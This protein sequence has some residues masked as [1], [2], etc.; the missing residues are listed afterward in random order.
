M[1][2]GCDGPSVDRIPPSVIRFCRSLYV[3]SSSFCMVHSK[4]HW[5][6]L[7]HSLSLVS[8]ESLR[9]LQLPPPV[10]K[11][12][13]SHVPVPAL[14][15]F[16]NQSTCSTLGASSFL[17]QQNFDEITTDCL[18]LCTPRVEKLTPGAEAQSPN[19]TVPSVAPDTS[20]HL[21]QLAFLHRIRPTHVRYRVVS[22]RRRC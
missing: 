16:G 17:G 13:L 8:T 3:F 11:D 18:A 21:E 6:Q 10:F 2:Y 5:I 20:R 15:R 1:C 7:V 14:S 4:R 9:I 12:R 19:Y 22:K